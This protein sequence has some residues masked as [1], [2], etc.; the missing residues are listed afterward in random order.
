MAVPARAV[1]CCA[2]HRARRAGSGTA[3][4]TPAPLFALTP[5]IGAR[6]CVSGAP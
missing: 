1:Q 2:F 6:P 3:G 5:L 4:R